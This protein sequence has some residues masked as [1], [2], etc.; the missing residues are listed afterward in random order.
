MSNRGNGP[1]ETIR[2][3][4]GGFTKLVLFA[5]GFCAM[6]SEV[7]WT[8]DFTPVLKTQV[9]SFA[10]I[11]LTYLAGDVPWIRAVSPSPGQ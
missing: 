9:Y 11:V 2:P 3:S 7:V 6:A 4:R 8:R 5:T 1:S 10:L